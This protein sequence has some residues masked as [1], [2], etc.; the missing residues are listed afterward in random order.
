[1]DRGPAG[2]PL[3]RLA[4]IDTGPGI[5]EADQQEIF[6]PFQQLAAGLKKGGTGLGLAITRRQ[7]ELMGGEV[8]LEST[9][10][11]GSRFYFEIPLPPAEG[12]L[13][14]VEAE[15]TREVVRLA[16]GSQVNALV[17]DDNQNN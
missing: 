12:Q 2:Q 5:S 7:V 6:E 1:G 14:S 17:V 11:K 15:E 8:K 4:V 3:V 9:L 13:E 10:G 16:P